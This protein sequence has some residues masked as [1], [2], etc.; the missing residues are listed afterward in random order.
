MDC[1]IF[2]LS[3]SLEEGPLDVLHCEY[4]HPFFHTHCCSGQETGLKVLKE[5]SIFPW[6]FSIPLHLQA[7]GHRQT[8][9]RTTYLAGLGEE[10][11]LVPYI[12]ERLGERSTQA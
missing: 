9:S 2:S 1:L 12:F 4:Y 3:T 8:F 7:V 11:P 5:P 6:Y 10:G